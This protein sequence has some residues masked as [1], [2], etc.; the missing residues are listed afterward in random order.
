MST[1]NAKE[2]Q[3]SVRLTKVVTCEGLPTRAAIGQKEMTEKNHPTCLEC[4]PIE[5]TR[6]VGVVQTRNEG[7][8]WVED[9]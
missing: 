8:P 5:R 2:P 4:G 9:N 1:G 7:T 3:W 6:K